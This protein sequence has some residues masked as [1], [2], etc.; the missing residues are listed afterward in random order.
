M[1]KMPV[2]T[3]NSDRDDIVDWRS[4]YLVKIKKYWDTGHP[5]FYID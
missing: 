2:E 5:I 3:K 1:E 4:R